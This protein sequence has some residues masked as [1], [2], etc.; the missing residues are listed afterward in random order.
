MFTTEYVTIPL[1]QRMKEDREECDMLEGTGKGKDC[2]GCSLYAGARFGCMGM[3]P[4]HRAEAA[5]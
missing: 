2:A 3:Y 4:W 1:T 5:G